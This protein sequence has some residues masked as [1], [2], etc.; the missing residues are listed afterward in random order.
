MVTS[1][2]V[3]LLF[4]TQAAEEFSFPRGTPSPDEGLFRH[5]LRPLLLAHRWS[6]SQPGFSISMCSRSTS[7]QFLPSCSLLPTSQLR[8]L[9]CT[10]NFQEGTKDLFACLHAASIRP[11]ENSTA[12]LVLSFLC[13]CQEW[14]WKIHCPNFACS[15]PISSVCQ[16]IGW[17]QLRETSSS[18]RPVQ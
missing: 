3:K 1:W 13:S 9:S 11:M 2:N 5:L 7:C 10:I 12:S 18:S 8:T 14:L 15:C 6:Y 17:K 4:Q 16:T